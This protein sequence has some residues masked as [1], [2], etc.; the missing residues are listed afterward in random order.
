[1]AVVGAAV[2]GATVVGAAVVGT[3]VVGAA[4][5]GAAVV[6]AAVV[7]ATVAATNEKTCDEVATAMV[8]YVSVS[9]GNM[10]CIDGHSLFPL[11]GSSTKNECMR[12]RPYSKA[13]SNYSLQQSRGQFAH[14]RDCQRLLFHRRSNARSFGARI[15]QFDL[16]IRL[17]GIAVN[18]G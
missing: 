6:G 17:I 5:V 18:G 2:V 14:C 16:Q 11:H 12:Q 15:S 13:N 1:M 10:M 7:G 4:V 9:W 3:S 8:V